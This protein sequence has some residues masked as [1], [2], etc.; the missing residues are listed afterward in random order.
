M[1]VQFQLDDAL[2]EELTRKTGRPKEDAIARLQEFAQICLKEWVNKA[3]TPD[4][5]DTD[6][7]LAVTDQLMDEYNEAF[8][9][10][11]R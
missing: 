2:L 5:F 7:V 10:L 1:N 4:V 9:E 6:A 3:Q 11:A 8:H